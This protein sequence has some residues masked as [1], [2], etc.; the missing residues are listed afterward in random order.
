[1]TKKG[2]LHVALIPSARFGESTDARIVIDTLGERIAIE[3][4]NKPY[5]VS[6]FGAELILCAV[7]ADN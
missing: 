2:A 5:N 3:D 6:I 7:A 1:M 4:L